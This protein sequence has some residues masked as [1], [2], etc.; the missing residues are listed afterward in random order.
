MLRKPTLNYPT[1]SQGL[2]QLAKAPQTGCLFAV[3]SLIR[4]LIVTAMRVP[5]DY[6]ITPKGGGAVRIIDDGESDCFGKYLVHVGQI[7]APTKIFFCEGNLRS[8]IGRELV[9]LAELFR[10]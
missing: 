4:E 10:F 2:R 9:G 1:I 6:G 3:S 7:R 8:E 5:L